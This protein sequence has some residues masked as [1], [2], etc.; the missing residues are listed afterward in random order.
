MKAGKNK[1]VLKKIINQNK[2]KQL[3]LSWVKYIFKPLESSQA[4]KL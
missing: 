4:F 2:N 1:R 3:Y